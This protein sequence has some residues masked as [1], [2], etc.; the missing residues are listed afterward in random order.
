[1]AEEGHLLA[2]FFGLRTGLQLEDLEGVL[3]IG[4][5]QHTILFVGFRVAFDGVL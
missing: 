2:E 1:M 5:L 4:V 3:K